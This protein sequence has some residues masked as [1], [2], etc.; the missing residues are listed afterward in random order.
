MGPE[1]GGGWFYNMGWWNP[2]G[3]D[4]PDDPMEVISKVQLAKISDNLWKEEDIKQE[5]I[6]ERLQEEIRESGAIA[7]ALKDVRQSIGKDRQEWKLAWS[8]NSNL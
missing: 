7:V 2:P 3:L 8:Q 5:E 6:P 1:G 4:K